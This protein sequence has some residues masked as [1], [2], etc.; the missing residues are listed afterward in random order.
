MNED[1]YSKYPDQSLQF[2]IALMQRLGKPKS[3]TIVRNHHFEVT[4]ANGETYKFGG[5]TVGYSGT[6]PRFAHQFL[7]AAGFNVSLH[8][9]ESMKPPVTL[10]S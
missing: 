1:H 6:G 7:A 4:F 9:V 2:A 5:F 10:T 3:C 8:E